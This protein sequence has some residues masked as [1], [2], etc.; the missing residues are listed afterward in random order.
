MLICCG[1]IAHEVPVPLLGVLSVI[2]PI[3][4]Q[5]HRDGIGCATPYWGSTSP[6]SPAFLLWGADF[7]G[8]APTH[9]R[10]APTSLFVTTLAQL[11]YRRAGMPT[12]PV[13]Q[14]EC[15]GRRER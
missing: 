13:R 6:G 9:Q 5:Q 10:R 15:Q 4:S 7:E 12:P 3:V 1:V 14:H 2:E 8:W 11:R